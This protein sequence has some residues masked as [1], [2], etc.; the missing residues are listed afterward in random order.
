MERMKPTPQ[1][2]AIAVRF[3]MDPFQPILGQRLIFTIVINFFCAHSSGIWKCASLS[4]EHRCHASPDGGTCSCPS[5]YIVNGNNSRSCI[6]MYRAMFT[7]SENHVIYLHAVVFKNHWKK[8]KKT[9]KRFYSKQILSFSESY[10][11][12][13]L[14]LLGSGSEQSYT[15][16]SYI[17]YNDPCNCDV[18]PKD[19]DDCSMWGV[20]DQLCE[21]RTGSHRCSC[22]DG[23]ILEQHRY[24]RADVSGTCHFLSPNA[25]KLHVL[26]I[27]SNWHI[28]HCFWKPLWLIYSTLLSGLL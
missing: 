24:C 23:Y 25:H 16:I 17:L 22:R 12:V 5:G 14:L 27:H 21:D 2:A 13:L 6:G 28:L 11:I 3:K 9:Q 15:I 18:H 20:C 26:I 8:P 7:F 1:L 4:C 10:S 19:F